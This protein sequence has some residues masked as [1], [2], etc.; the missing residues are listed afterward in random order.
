MNTITIYS[1]TD[2]KINVNGL[3]YGDL[4]GNMYFVINN[5]Y[6]IVSLDYYLKE[7]IEFIK[8]KNI[9]NFKKN[10]EEFKTNLQN[11]KSGTI[12]QSNLTLKGMAQ[13]NIQNMSDDEKDKFLDNNEYFG[14]S[15]NI[16]EKKYYWLKHNDDLS[17]DDEYNDNYY[18]NGFI[19]ISDVSEKY[20]IVHADV[21]S[22]H[23]GTFDVFLIRGDLTSKN[24]IS[25]MEKQ[26]KS[27]TMFLTIY[28][29]GY[30][31]SNFIDKIKISRICFDI[32][33]NIPYLKEHFANV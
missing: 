10:Y 31:K 11:T 23:K 16:I 2:E 27:S 30:V 17:S 8:I 24:I 20:G 4:N 21:L 6:Y 18:L 33:N 32:E 15:D 25:T 9:N 14:E 28:T 29:D 19:N 13:E 1:N 22:I 7:G 5:D 12:N 26:N 3:F